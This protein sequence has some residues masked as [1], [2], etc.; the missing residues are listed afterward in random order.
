[1]KA[2]QVRKLKPGEEHVE[3]CTFG[4]SKDKYVEYDY[5]H[6]DGELYSTISHTVEKARAK[7]DIWLSKKR[8][9]K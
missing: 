3:K 7:R 4:A 1:M 8:G 5:R 2:Y 6:T 9:D